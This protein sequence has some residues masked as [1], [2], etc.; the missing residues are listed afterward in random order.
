MRGSRSASE[1]GSRSYRSNSAASLQFAQTEPYEEDTLLRMTTYDV[2]Y[3]TS[4]LPNPAASTGVQWQSWNAP[5]RQDLYPPLYPEGI[6]NPRSA[7]NIQSLLS[8][9]EYEASLLPSSISLRSSSL[10]SSHLSMSSLTSTST[11]DTSLP[12]TPVLISSSR[13]STS[14]ASPQPTSQGKPSV[15]HCSWCGHSGHQKQTCRD[16]TKAFKDGIVHARKG[17][18]CLGRPG[19]GGEPIPYPHGEKTL[20]DWVWKKRESLENEMRSGLLRAR[21][22]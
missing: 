16:L 14:S 11:F 8:S 10:S 20:R 21:L 17:K 7:S 6:H 2:P 19:E 5:S 18:I 13:P 22:R 12:G 3:M 15:K 9:I 1:S 4:P